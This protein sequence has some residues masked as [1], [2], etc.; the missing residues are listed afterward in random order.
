[1]N[2]FTT[3]LRREF[4][5]HRNVF[6]FVPLGLSAFL[7]LMMTLSLFVM[8]MDA[9]NDSELNISTQGQGDSSY[10]SDWSE[11]DTALVRDIY[12]H[13]IRELADADPEH[14]QQVMNKFL[15]MLS[16][17]VRTVL[18]F[19]IFFYLL[20]SL[21][22][23]RKD[24]SVMFWKSMPVS[25][26]KEVGSKLVSGLMV[27]PLIALA[28]IAVTDI[29]ALSMGSILAAL[30]DTSIWSVIWSPA[31]LIY[32]W[33]SMAL[34]FL[35]QVIWLFPVFAWI[36]FVSAF[37]R[38]I[39]LLWVFGIPIAIMIAEKVLFSVSW[40]SQFIANH[41]KPVG[42]LSMQSFSEYSLQT[43]QLAEMFTDIELWV[44]IVAGALLIYGAVW[45]RG[46]SDG[47]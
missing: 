2:Q 15:V 9:H 28:C 40:F 25:D 26:F 14:R 10:E 16:A 46:R 20:G 22:D 43:W 37:A 23:E 45:K 5:E 11:R 33:F 44:G 32:H 38:S 8:N 7:V 47:S 41:M 3:L 35:M 13:K 1:M 17:P 34:Y 6:L 18:L 24:Q 29:C 42:Q 27:A 21:Y 39:P 30:A 31:N 36:V 19:V 4:W 12:I